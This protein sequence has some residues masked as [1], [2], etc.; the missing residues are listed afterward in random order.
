MTE[1]MVNMVLIII[2]LFLTFLTTIL[3]TIKFRSK[4]CGNE[5]TFRPSSIPSP[6]RVVV[7]DDKTNPER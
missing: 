3:T 6:E 2:D 7:V 5:V 4:C 1:L